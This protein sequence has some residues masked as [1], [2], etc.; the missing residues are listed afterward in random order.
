MT[1]ILHVVGARPNFVKAAPVLRALAGRAGVRQTLVHTGQHYDANMSDVFFVQLGVPAPDVS[2][3][4]GSGTHAAQTAQVLA[5]LEPVLLEKKPDAV[6]VYG[7][8]NSTV[9]AALAAAKLRIPLAHV[10]AGLRSGDRDMPEELNRLVTDQLADLLLTPSKDADLNLAREGIPSSRVRFVGNAMIDTLIRLLPAAKRPAS[11]RLESPYVLVT[12][13]RPSNTDEP[14][15]LLKLMRALSEIAR[16]APVVFPIHPRTRKRLGEAGWTPP[17]GAELLLL[18]PLGYL[19]FLALQRDAAL[20]VTDSGGIQEETTFL[21][22]PC[23]TVRTTTER[24]VT[25]THGTNRLVKDAAALPKAA[26]A[27]LKKKRSK[28]GPPKYW[29]GKAGERIASAVLA[30]AQRRAAKTAS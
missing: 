4:V 13:H 24:P 2:L 26:A 6:V 28:A 10:E 5:G 9:A 27:A 7:D 15:A 19:E 12:V 16:T 23:L 29:D 17:A 25:V 3:G 30:L 21:G 8:V 20:V 1:H 22:V 11:P 14:A 18:E